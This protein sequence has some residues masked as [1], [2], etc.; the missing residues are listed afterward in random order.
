MEDAIEALRLLH[1]RAPSPVRF[2]IAGSAAVAPGYARRLL[3][4]AVRYRLNGSVRFHLVAVPES[5][6]AD[7]YSAADALV[8]L[9]E[10]QC[11]GLGIF[12]ALACDLPVIVSRSCGAHEVLE[13]R[14][15]AMLVAR[16]H[17]EEIARAVAD[18]VETPG[19]A[20][21]L[22]REARARVLGRITW[23]AY[24]RN[25]LRVFEQVLEDQHER[26]VPARREAFA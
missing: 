25:L 4:L 15:T 9:A 6:M 21:K 20:E 18:L 8:Y 23:E 14:E 10:N 24:A 1:L 22:A 7:Y 26:V 16:R 13:H 11:W 12:E 19:L 5:E 3:D 17:P 2:L